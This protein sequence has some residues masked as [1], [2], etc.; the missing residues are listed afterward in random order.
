MPTLPSANTGTAKTNEPLLLPGPNGSLTAAVWVFSFAVQRL[1]QSRSSSR[2]GGSLSERIIALAAHLSCFGSGICL[3][4]RVLR[5]FFGFPMGSLKR[6]GPSPYETAQLPGGVTHFR[7]RYPESA[8]Q[9]TAPSSPRKL[10]LVVLV[11]GFSA[12]HTDMG[13]IAD[14]LL[15]TG[16]VRVLQYDNVGRGCVYATPLVVGFWVCTC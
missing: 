10:P 4:L 13:L 14:A 7:L 5:I 11:H 2:G 8:A 15:E 3:T 6:A 12:E 16:S 1:L 9:E